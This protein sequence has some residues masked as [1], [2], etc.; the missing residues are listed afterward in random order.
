MRRSGLRPVWY[1]VV[2]VAMGEGAQASKDYTFAVGFRSEASGM[3]AIALG[4]TTLASGDYSLAAGIGS[5]AEG[6]QS[7]A[8]G[9]DAKGDLSMALGV[10]TVANSFGA[11]VLGRYNE[12]FVGLDNKEV[13]PVTWRDVDPIL[14]VGNG[15]DELNRNNAMILYKNGDLHV[16]AIYADLQESSDRR[17]KKDIRPFTGALEKILAVQPVY[18]SFKDTVHYPGGECIG[19]L[20]QDLER[21]LPEMIGRDD[22]GYLT[23]KYSKM[24]AVLLQAIKEQQQTIE[25][26]QKKVAEMENEKTEIA[27]LKKELDE[28]RK[29]IFLGEQRPEK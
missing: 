28:L 27:Q 15:T 6:K 10:G 1:M 18:Y 16:K 25:A 29:S 7:I 11:L 17:L 8:F 4:H 5:M 14:V 21:S 13:S 22:K 19:F 2:A 24:T 23:V 26:L 20:A 3:N 9:G 12:D